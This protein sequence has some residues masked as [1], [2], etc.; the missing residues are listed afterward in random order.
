MVYED[1]FRWLNNESL[2]LPDTPDGALSEHLAADGGSSESPHLDGS[3]GSSGALD[4]DPGFWDVEEPDPARLR[5]LQARAE[6]E[7]LPEFNLIRIL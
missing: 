5:D 6:A 2:Q 4:D 7:Q 3:A 1:V